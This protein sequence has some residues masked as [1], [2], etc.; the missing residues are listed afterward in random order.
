MQ[1]TLRT[2]SLTLFLFLPFLGFAM[3][4]DEKA[5]FKRQLK[6]ARTSDEMEQVVKNKRQGSRLFCLEFSNNLFEPL[7]F[8]KKYNDNPVEG[9][10][11]KIVR[12]C[13]F[14]EMQPL[15]ANGPIHDDVKNAVLVRYQRYIWLNP[16]VVNELTNI[17]NTNDNR[18][19]ALRLECIR[20]QGVE[21]ERQINQNFQREMQALRKWQ[22]QSRIFIGL[23]LGGIVMCLAWKVFGTKQEQQNDEGVEAEP[24]SINN[25]DAQ[26]A[27]KGT[28]S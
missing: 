1:M 17:F 22:L 6:A 28:I 21:E 4:T 24:E 3:S 19:K 15:I 20:L 7:K 26:D 10:V 23:V 14:E 27:L 5:E 18:M 8:Q 9:D 25:D 11:I 16:A 13:F 12:E 2:I